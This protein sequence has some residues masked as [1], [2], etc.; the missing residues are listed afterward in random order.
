MPSYG[1]LANCG[2]S[3]YEYDSR[4][5]N[6]PKTK[7]KKGAYL[8]STN[9]WFVP[10][11]K[12][13]LKEHN[14]TTNL[15]DIIYLKWLLIIFK[16]CG[17]PIYYSLVKYFWFKISIKDKPKEKILPIDEN[18][19]EKLTLYRG[20]DDEYTGGNKSHYQPRINPIGAPIVSINDVFNYA[21]MLKVTI[22]LRGRS[23]Y[24]KRRG[25]FHLLGK[26]CFWALVNLKRMFDKG[27]LNGT[28]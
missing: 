21:K 9:L 1:Y 23:W 28:F 15:D 7:P 26:S 2:S 5:N 18:T 3:I 11:H 10:G 6:K 14:R 19:K 17:I 25:E 4:G 13:L 22:E 27:D 20:K 12:S 24:Y 8:Y 16:Y